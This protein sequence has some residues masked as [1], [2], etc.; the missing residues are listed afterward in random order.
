[1]SRTFAQALPS[2]S[3]SRRARRRQIVTPRYLRHSTS[4][5]LREKVI[6]SRPLPA[7]SICSLRLVAS[8]K[9]VALLRP[10]GFLRSLVDNKSG[11]EAGER[12]TCISH[13]P[14]ANTGA[15]P[16]LSGA[17]AGAGAA[18]CGGK[19]AIAR[20]SWRC[21]RLYAV[22]IHCGRPLLAPASLG[23]DEALTRV[24]WAIF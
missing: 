13:P 21:A 1:M 15:Y 5:D 17:A 20:T 4:R 22:R 6:A 14:E 10:I 2:L 3:T 8:A 23:F 9:L 12:T 7:G 19:M 11:A 24:N 16:R 18:T